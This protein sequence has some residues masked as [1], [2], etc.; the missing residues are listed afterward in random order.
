ME[1]DHLRKLGGVA[2]E[3]KNATDYIMYVIIILKSMYVSYK[4]ISSIKAWKNEDQAKQ[5]ERTAAIIILVVAEIL[6]STY[7]LVLSAT[8]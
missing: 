7:H 6:V 3:E 1:E 4:I 5:K 2:G 8:W